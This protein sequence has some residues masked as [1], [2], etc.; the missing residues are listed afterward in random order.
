M[1]WAE[2]N[3]PPVQGNQVKIQVKSAALN[4]LDTLMIR[5]QYQVKPL[6]PFT[7]GVEIA[8]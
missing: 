8:G 6:L 7:P 2:I 5:G 4:F 3:L 1:D